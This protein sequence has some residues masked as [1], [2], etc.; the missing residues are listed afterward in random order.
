MSPKPLRV[1]LDVSAAL[2][3]VA[4][5][6]R[7]ERELAVA[8]HSLSDG[9]ELVLF[10][11]KQEVNSL[12]MALKGVP[13]IKIPWSNRTWRAWLLA[14]FG[15]PR[16]W[17]KAIGTCDVFHGT[18]SL[19]PPTKVPTVLTI[20]DL[21]TTLF[22]QHHTRLHRLYARYS[23]PRMAQAATA[24]I[25]DSAAVRQDVIIHLHIQPEKVHVIHLGVDHQR[26]HPRPHAEA[27]QMVVQS[28]GVKLPY[29]L[30]VGTL[31]PRKNLEMFLRA[32]AELP[33]DRPQA[34]IVGARGWGES[35]LLNVI[36]QLGLQESVHF[37]G[38]VDDALLPVLYAGAECLVYPSL[39]EG[40][41]LPIL[42]AMACGT[43][44]IASNVSSMP[45]VGG[46]AARLFNPTEQSSLK[47]AI[48]EVLSDEGQRAWM[49]TAGLLRA[50]EFTWAR[51]A[52]QTLELYRIVAAAR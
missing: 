15:L 22:P 34:V 36:Q 50:D 18:D 23:L 38:F 32:Y 30:T 45:E 33:A 42:E 48:L 12:P 4:G 17:S 47:Q 31:E 37:T 1:C 21:T 40:F 27:Q 28:L 25:T 2:S 24:V 9:P 16:A 49:R 29:I 6:G 19:I 52:R 13:R 35:S 8:L 26:F 10:N 11:N 46:A 7:Y 43:P 44:V 14:G 5:I 51:T 3:Q 41:G 39:Y 20:H